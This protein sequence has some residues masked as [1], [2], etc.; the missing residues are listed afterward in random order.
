[1][2]KTSVIH[3]THLLLRRPRIFDFVLIALLQAGCADQPPV[4]SA[5]DDQEQIKAVRFTDITAEAGL[6]SFQ[7]E[8]GGYGDMTMPEIMGSGGGFIDYDADGHLDIILV[9]GGS[10]PG[11]AIKEV[12]ALRLWRNQGNGTFIEQTAEAGIANEHAYGFGVAAADYDNDGDEDILLT[13]LG[14]NLL[15]QNEEGAF[16]EIGRLAGIAGDDKWSTS[17][18]FFDADRD[19]HLDIYIA[20][21]LDWSPQ[22]DV[23]CIEDGQRDYC[24]P[25]NYR[26]VGDTFYHNNGDGTFTDRTVEAGFNDIAGVLASKGLGVSELD[27]NQDG[28]PDL[29]V[30]NDGEPNFLFKNLGDGTFEEVALISGVAVDQNGTPRAGMGVGAGIIDSTG[31]QSIFVGNFSEEMVGLWRV[32]QGTFFE[33]RSALSKIGFSTVP[34]LTFGL[35]LFD[36]DLDTDLDLLLANGHVMKYISSKQVGVSFRQ[37]PQM[38]LNGGDGTFTASNTGAPFFTEMLGRGLAVGDIDLDGD[39]DALFTEN[40]GPAHLWRNNLESQSFFKLVLQGEKSNRDGLGAQVRAQVGDLVMERRARTG[41]SYL[42]QS[43]KAISFGLGD[44]Q[45]INWLEVVWPSGIVERF[46]NL[47]A[48]QYVLLVEGTGQLVSLSENTL[49][50]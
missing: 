8:N 28:W 3:I 43:E 16:S 36:V 39:L 29:Y 38:F 46:D 15:Y 35:V 9:Q 30:S 2:Q 5:S 31:L 17:A 18:L 47:N 37:Q 14:R 21:Y 45:V 40:N 42:S 33:D 25:L 34:T 20:N 50:L 11:Q 7:H 10:L 1:M 12:P 4:S 23:A 6:G 26:G 24:N 13:T 44:H 19:G 41:G 22:N 32:E 48:N 49:S 27:Y